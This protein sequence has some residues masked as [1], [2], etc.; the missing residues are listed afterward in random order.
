MTSAGRPRPAGG[1]LSQGEI[2]ELLALDVPARLATIDPDGFPRIT[3]IWFVWEDGAFHM[4]SV[5]GR[6][7]LRNLAEEPRASICIDTES[8]ES[9]RGVR[10]NRQIKARGFAELR[11][12]E[13][14]YWTRRITAKY[15]SGPEGEARG[16]YRAAMGRIVIVLRPS[17]VLGTRAP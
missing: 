10:S 2:G 12:D 7:H 9:V 16:A 11:P 6:P 15:V 8:R 4:T 5:A 17:Q 3:P 1:R 14:G 13:G